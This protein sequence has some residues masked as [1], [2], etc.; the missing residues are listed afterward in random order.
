MDDSMQETNSSLDEWNFLLSDVTSSID[1]ACATADRH[2]IKDEIFRKIGDLDVYHQILQSQY[3]VH[4]KDMKESEYS[5]QLLNDFFTEAPIGYIILNS[6]GIIVGANFAASEFWSIDRHRMRGLGL[7]GLISGDHIST[8]SKAIEAAKISGQ[9]KTFD[10]KC[11]KPGGKSFW[12]RF[13]IIQASKSRD[14]QKYLLCSIIDITFDRILEDATKKTTIGLSSS[15]GLSFFK[16]LVEFLTGYH[17]IDYAV[18]SSSSSGKEFIPLSAS[19]SKYNLKELRYSYEKNLDSLKSHPSFFEPNSYNLSFLTKKLVAKDGLAIFLF[20]SNRKIAGQLVIL[21]SNGFENKKLYSSIL[22]IVSLRAAAELQR[23]KAEEELKSYRD[24]LE[25]LVEKRASELIT[26]NVKLALEIEKRKKTEKNLLAAKYQAEEATKVKSIFLAN[27][28]HEIRTPM[29]GIIG[30]TALMQRMDVPEK[31]QNYVKMIQKSGES[32]LHII[33]DI[34]DISKLESGRTDFEIRE[35]DLHE[36]LHSVFDVKYQKMV[37]KGV[38]PFLTF[39]G[40]CPALVSS[41][42]VRIRQVVE[43]LMSNAIKFTHEGCVI[44]KVSFCKKSSEIK[45]EVIDSGIGL[46][47][48]QTSLVFERFAQADSSTTRKYGGTGLGLSICR[49]ITRLLGGDIECTSAEGEGST[50]SFWLPVEAKAG[51]RQDVSS[52]VPKRSSLFVTAM[53][54][55]RVNLAMRESFEANGLKTCSLDTMKQQDQPFEKIYVISDTDVSGCKSLKGITGDR[56]V[57]LRGGVRSLDA[58]TDLPK[59][60]FY[61]D[62]LFSIENILKAVCALNDQAVATEASHTPTQ[63]HFFDGVSVLLAE[64][65][66]INKVVAMD[67]L[68]SMGASVDVAEDGL[69]AV[70]L[71]ATND[72]D[73]ILMDCLMPVLDGFEALKQIRDTHGCRRPVVALTANAMKGDREA[74][75]SAG[76]DEYISKPINPEDLARISSLLERGGG[77]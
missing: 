32:L 42:K 15:T 77:S 8:L 3:Q 63:E 5:S 27:M 11:M 64:D 22:K 9:R 12:G 57:Y 52:L 29:N 58:E 23:Y 66:E 56:V 54:D 13:D 31:L 14:D 68:E 33:N 38:Q 70:G 40:D 72:Y 35:F 36:L 39:S 60:V 30:V 21:S 44:V 1:K 45:V 50:F 7:F 74:C 49:K 19:V 28:S 47:K 16:H 37:A 48:K 61:A 51:S 46:S 75:L 25:Q 43:N 34:L 20:D 6:N 73:L 69:Q 17:N 62:N 41:D 76:F 4:L 55:R 59:N 53:S 18:I 26:K 24:S 65:N 10:V 71:V 2:E 67:L